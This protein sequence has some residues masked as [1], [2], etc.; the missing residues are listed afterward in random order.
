LPHSLEV[1]TPFGEARQYHCPGNAQDCWICADVCIRVL[2]DLGYDAG[3][4]GS[5]WGDQISHR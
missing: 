5:R 1:A 2:A 3:P 4:A